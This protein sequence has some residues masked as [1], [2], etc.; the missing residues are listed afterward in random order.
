MQTADARR[1]ATLQQQV[2]Q[3][4]QHR[5]NLETRLAGTRSAVARLQVV[6]AR[7]KAEIAELAL[8]KTHNDTA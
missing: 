7:Q 8:Q 4:R 6:V 5:R 2:E 1:I 3:E